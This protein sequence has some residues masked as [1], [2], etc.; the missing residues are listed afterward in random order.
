MPPKA[1]FRVKL[2]SKQQL[3]DFRTSFA[4][5]GTLAERKLQRKFQ[6]ESN[7]SYGED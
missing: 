6:R 3:E 5:P 1:S 7:F 2:P 4:L